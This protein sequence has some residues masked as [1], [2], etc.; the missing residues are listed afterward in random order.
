MTLR[1]L[2]YARYTSDNQ[3]A[4]SIEDQQRIFSDYVVGLSPLAIARNLNAEGIPGPSGGP[5]YH[6][7][8]RGRPTREDGILRNRVYIGEL[9]WNRRRTVTHPVS[10]QKLR[11]TNPVSDIVEARVPQLRI[12]DDALW[13]AAQ[14][15]LQAE[16]LSPDSNPAPA[17]AGFWNRRRPQHL[18]SGKTFCGLCGGPF[19]MVGGSYLGCIATRN[20]GCRNTKTLRRPA[21]EAIVL[22]ALSTELMQPDALAAFI[23]GF[24][25]VWRRNARQGKA[26]SETTRRELQKVEQ[27][28]ERL[29]DMITSG[30]GGPNIHRRL[31][32]L[33]AQ[34]AKLQAELAKAPTA[35]P[36]LHPGLATTYRRRMAELQS[37]L[38]DRDN[39]EALEQ[40]RSLIDRVIIPP[41]VPPED[42]CQIEL[43]GALANLLKATGATIP[44]PI[45]PAGANTDRNLFDI[46]AKEATGG[47]APRLARVIRR[48]ARR[49]AA[50][51][52]RRA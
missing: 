24:N 11:R 34:Q 19:G 25:E 33:E 52:G 46:S 22:G 30:Q 12:I 10:G 26:A 43:V 15:R 32:E 47:G 7:S 38:A 51:R 1:V 9:V 2:T 42:P 20:G 39:P 16:A 37:A 40:A 4:F 3:S 5:W 27:K 45:T 13:Q 8:I 49:R 31:T 29:L 50:G 41:G 23:D 14:A 48:P 18:L 28:I 6:P 44:P 36:G 17:Q 35:A 21:L